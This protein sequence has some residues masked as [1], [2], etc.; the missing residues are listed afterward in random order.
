MIDQSIPTSTILTKNQSQLST[1]DMNN[2]NNATT[3]NNNN[4][5]KMRPKLYKI[6]RELDNYYFLCLDHKEISNLFYDYYMEFTPST[7]KKTFLCLFPLNR[8]FRLFLI[9]CLFYHSIWWLSNSTSNNLAINYSMIN[10]NL[11]TILVYFNFH[12]LLITHFLIRLIL[13]NLIKS[14]N[15]ISLGKLKQM[16]NLFEFLIYFLVELYV[17]YTL[18]NHTVGFICLIMVPHLFFIFYHKFDINITL[19]NVN[20]LSNQPYKP[21]LNIELNHQT[22]NFTDNNNI[23]YNNNNNNNNSNNN[24]QTKSG[25]NQL[26]Y[27][28]CSNMSLSSFLNQSIPGTLV[29]Q[30]DHTNSNNSNNNIKPIKQYANNKLSKQTSIKPSKVD[31]QQS[32]SLIRKFLNLTIIKKPLD[33][34]KYLFRS[35]WQ[36]IHST[37]FKSCSIM[38]LKRNI[39]VVSVNST[40][41]SSTV[42]NIG[43]YSS[44][45]SSSAVSASANANDQQSI[46][47]HYDLY[48]NS[49]LQHKCQKDG[50][51]LREETEIFKCD[52]NN[53]LR[54]IVINTIE[55]VYF[56]FFI[57]R[58][59]VPAQLNVRE[60]EYYLYL[61]S[62]LLCTFVSFWLYFIPLSFI[63]SL[64]R[65][66]EHLG[67][68]RLIDDASE[69]EIKQQLDSNNQPL[70]IILPVGVTLWMNSKIYYHGDKVYY[71]GKL[72]KCESTYCSSVPG[73]KTHDKFYRMF[74][75]PIKMISCLLV[76]KL[77]NLTLLIAY[78]FINRR[79][80]SIITNIVELLSNCHTFFMLLRDFFIMNKRNSKKTAVKE[81][82][83][84]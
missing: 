71:M 80:Y 83:I 37:F 41:Q 34:I 58:I 24:N 67:R 22:D 82:K 72:Y 48:L 73:N 40:S 42:T 20:L 26:I 25:T 39:F 5:Q 66:S 10:P 76:M 56:N 57:T 3:N 14:F 78:G 69:L 1:N 61:I 35:I 75:N 52:Y 21:N 36:Y 19:F 81:D 44:Q 13:F 70:S 18:R 60:T 29:T 15:I 32:M 43:I 51:N 30:L 50:I 33:F 65:N 55:S 63:I 38:I 9:H 46:F 11:F 74:S 28:D 49:N 2:V 16:L 77:V 62:S 6:K 4:S 54:E 17:F 59:C 64:N 23:S 47:Q 7:I 84:D 12:D 68:W 31:N 27:T 8:F 45:N 53:R 79:W